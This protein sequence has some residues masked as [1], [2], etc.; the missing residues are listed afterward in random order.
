LTIIAK[1][2]KVSANT[3]GIKYKFGIQVPI[4]IKN[5]INLGKKNGKNRFEEAIITE[6]KQL[7]IIRHS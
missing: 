3:T 4:G 6:L 1:A 7:H 5:E 2:Q